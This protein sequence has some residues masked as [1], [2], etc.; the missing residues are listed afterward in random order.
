MITLWH[1]NT[2]TFTEEAGLKPLRTVLNWARTLWALKT[3]SELPQTKIGASRP[4]PARTLGMT[5][6]PSWAWAPTGLGPL[7]TGLNVPSST[8][9]L[10]AEGSHCSCDRKEW[11]LHRRSVI[12]TNRTCTRSWGER[13]VS[14]SFWHWVKWF[15]NR[16]I[17]TGGPCWTQEGC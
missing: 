1:G 5:I 7:A 4:S 9:I 15:V 8:W 14:P 10:E 6:A 13:K 12:A 11:E 16:L 17:V 3:W 2:V